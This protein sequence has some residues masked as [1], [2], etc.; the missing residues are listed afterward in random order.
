MVAV[1]GVA[2]LAVTVACRST[3]P[4]PNV[5]NLIKDL[6][7]PDPAV[8]GQANLDLIRL[9]EPSVPP[10]V[11]MLK[12]D[13]VRLRA[14][15]ATALWGLGDK[16]RAAAPALAESLGDPEASVRVAAAMALQNMGEHAK[17]AVPALIRSLK[18][19]DAKVRQWSAK[20]LGTI[21]PAAEKAVP[22]LVQ[23]AKTE[24]IR[25]AAEEAIRKIR[26]LPEGQ[27]VPVE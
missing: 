15:A 4:R 18:D 21:G 17:E 16:A 6:Q 2:T 5:P 8:S 22:A 7:N 19:R 25:P 23:A 13:E 14:L 9:G 1:V 27:P 11:E 3:P 10:L 12:S 20:A 24:G 26:G